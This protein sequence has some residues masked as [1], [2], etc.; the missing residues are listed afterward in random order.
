MK[1]CS[2]CKQELPLEA[3]FKSTHRKSGLSNSCKSCEKE[4]SRTCPK[5]LYSRWKRHTTE[6]GKE[7]SL[8]FLE[9]KEIT[10]STTCNICSIEFSLSSKHSN[11]T[12][13]RINN[14]IGYVPGNCAAICH[15]CNRLKND[16]SL[17]SLRRIL[18]YMERHAARQEAELTDNQVLSSQIHVS[19]C[20]SN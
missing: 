11:K 13:D 16:N 3:F 12:I 7:P 20:P 15:R 8:S 18:A 19:G 2:T 1:K 14:S 10:A 5:V 9:W 6:R 4:R 17:K